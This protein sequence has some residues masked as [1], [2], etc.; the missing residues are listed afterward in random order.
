MLNKSILA[1][2][3][4]ALLF[5]VAVNSYS[6]GATGSACLDGPTAQFGRYIGDWK[7]EDQSFARDGSGWKPEAGAR[8]IFECVGDGLAVQDYWMPNDGG[9]GTNLRTYNPDTGRWEI[10]WT[11]ESLNGLMHISAEQDADGAIVMDIIS[12]VQDP[13]QRIT[14]FPPDDSGWD[15]VMEWSFDDG[16]TW[17]PVYRIRATPWGGQSDGGS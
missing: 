12:P 5:A 16:E 3:V 14:F 17:T 10:V 8:W 15:W 11:A 4:G 2:A 1:V 7:I 13:P 6:A 9:Y